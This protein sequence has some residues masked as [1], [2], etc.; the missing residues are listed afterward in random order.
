MRTPPGQAIPRTSHRIAGRTTITRIELADREALLR[1]AA[2]PSADAYDPPAI[3]QKDLLPPNVNRHLLGP[4]VIGRLRAA[5][6]ANA[7]DDLHLRLIK[8]QLNWGNAQVPAPLHLALAFTQDGMSVT[9]PVFISALHS[10]GAVLPAAARSAPWAAALGE[11]TTPLPGPQRQALIEHHLRGYLEDA[12]G[13]TD[14][15]VIAVPGLS[16]AQRQAS[17]T[18]RAF[19][20]L[21]AR[22]VIPL[23]S[24]DGYLLPHRRG[25]AAGLGSDPALLRKLR[26]LRAVW[27][28]LSADPAAREAACGAADADAADARPALDRQRHLMTLLNWIRASWS[29]SAQG[30]LTGG[31][32]V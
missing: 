24:W 9:G 15:T 28:A 26:V 25:S 2:R 14:L 21:A 7:I 20:A 32:H 17:P 12:A 29:G 6:H 1:L 23:G 11:I 4:A 13:E 16:P 19:L 31:K 30:R 10:A 8:Q 3:G 27:S 5:A 18:H 22:P